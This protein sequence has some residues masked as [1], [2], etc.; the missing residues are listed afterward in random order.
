VACGAN[1]PYG[2]ITRDF[3]ELS[4]RMVDEMREQVLR[5]VRR[6]V[7]TTLGAFRWRLTSGGRASVQ[8]RER[9]TGFGSPSPWFIHS[10]RGSVRGALPRCAPQERC[11]QSTAICVTGG[12]VP[13]PVSIL[14]I[15]SPPRRIASPFEPPFE[16][17]RQCSPRRAS[18]AV[19][20]EV[21]RGVRTASR[22]A[23]PQASLGVCP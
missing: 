10:R 15:Y 5:A 19:R 14:P 17:P 7:S 21:R 9:G 8:K 23:L 12:V 4:A 6:C 2:D 3:S 11:G 20:A 16:P 13:P 1:L 18:R 22:P